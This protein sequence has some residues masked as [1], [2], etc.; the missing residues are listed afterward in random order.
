MTRFSQSWMCIVAH[1]CQCYFSYFYQS[2]PNFFRVHLEV[3]IVLKSCNSLMHCA[4]HVVVAAVFGEET[5]VW[6]P[7]TEKARFRIRNIQCLP[8]VLEHFL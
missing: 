6:W 2:L 1:C 3:K 7:T 4:Q 5:V 8:K